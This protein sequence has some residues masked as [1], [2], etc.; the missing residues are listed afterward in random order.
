MLDG[1]GEVSG[2][3]GAVDV[4]VDVLGID[5]AVGPA[6][7]D[8]QMSDDEIDRLIGERAQA[9]QEKRFDDADAIRDAL[10][11]A[12]VNLEDGPNGTRWLRR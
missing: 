5:D 3:A 12:G 2:I 6:V 11:E 10:D 8:V 9:R 1:G 7:G 4:I